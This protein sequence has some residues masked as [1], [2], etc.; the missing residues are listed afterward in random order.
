MRDLISDE[1]SGPPSEHPGTG[2]A[3]PK[4]GTGGLLQ[5]ALARQNLQTAW[6]RVKA[7]KGAAGVDG[8]DIEQTAQVIRQRWPEIRQVTLPS[9]RVALSPRFT[10]PFYAVPRTSVAQTASG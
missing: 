4:A 8:L 6:R 7:N 5:A 3:K 9:F 2:S 1:A 10:R